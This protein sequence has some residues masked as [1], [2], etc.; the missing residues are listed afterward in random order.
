MSKSN[1]ESGRPWKM[2]KKKHTKI[3]GRRRKLGKK[4]WS[5][6]SKKPY[7]RQQP[8][9]SWMKING[10]YEKFLFLLR[11]SSQSEWAELREIIS[12]FI[13]KNK[14][15]VVKDDLRSEEKFAKA[16]F[17]DGYLKKYGHELSAIG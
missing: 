16:A 3:S 6:M 7:S 17:L 8:T 14:T 15:Y 5:D 13:R 2:A 4:K 10:D 1:K 9:Y 12:E 11:D